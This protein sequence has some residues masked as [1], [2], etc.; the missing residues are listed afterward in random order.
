M[1]KYDLHRFGFVLKKITQPMR[2]SNRRHPGFTGAWVFY[3]IFHP[4]IGL[5]LDAFFNQKEK[6]IEEVQEENQE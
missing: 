3:N 4:K 6:V 2:P 1:D 5:V